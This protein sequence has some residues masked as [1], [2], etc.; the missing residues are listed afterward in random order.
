MNAFYPKSILFFVFSLCADFLFAQ[1]VINHFAPTSGPVGTSVTITGSNFDPS[2]TNNIVYFGAVKANVT[3]ASA[4]ALTVVVPTGL[5]AQSISV[6]TN[7]LTG[8]S[9][10][11][12]ALTFYG[13]GVLDTNFIK[14][15]DIPI[16][17]NPQNLISI[18]ID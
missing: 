15:T 13:G 1:P 17:Y 4:T 9:S 10:I 2:A 18:D 5:S 11:P 12:F 3:G 7:G 8:F 6:T 16:S 14:R